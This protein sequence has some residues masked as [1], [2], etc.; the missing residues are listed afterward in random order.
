LI[1]AYNTL[2]EEKSH[3]LTRLKGLK[4][5]TKLDDVD[6]ELYLVIQEI[7]AYIDGINQA[8][9]ILEDEVFVK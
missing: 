2:M 5:T 8:L 7:E 4:E 1:Y 6:E 3:L 9:E